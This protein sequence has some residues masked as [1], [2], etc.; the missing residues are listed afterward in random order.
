[1]KAMIIAGVQVQMPVK[2]QNKE[3]KP[4]LLWCQDTSGKCSYRDEN[5]PANIGIA[6]KCRLPK[7]TKC[8]RNYPKPT[9]QRPLFRC[10]P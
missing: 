4:H 2:P 1:M 5:H 8:V 10:S 3:K 7:N 9:V 6:K